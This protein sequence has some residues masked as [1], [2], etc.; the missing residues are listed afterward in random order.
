MIIDTK[1]IRSKN[2]GLPL[3]LTVIL[4]SSIRVGPLLNHVGTLLDRCP[5]YMRQNKSVYDTASEP[6]AFH[7]T[8]GETTTHAG[9]CVGIG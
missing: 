5:W 9:Q 2:G 7:A 6:L 3:W 4:L 1:G 8:L